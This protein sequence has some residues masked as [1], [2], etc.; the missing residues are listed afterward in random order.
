MADKSDVIRNVWK[1][2]INPE[3]EDRIKDLQELLS[4][5]SPKNL[6]K[7]PS[8]KH[9]NIHLI[10]SL[11]TWGK[12]R[13]LFEDLLFKHSFVALDTTFAIIPAHLQTHPAVDEIVGEIDPKEK[14]E[15][16]SSSLIKN[17]PEEI[18]RLH[19]IIIGF[20]SG[21]M[22][23]FETTFLSKTMLTPLYVLLTQD[24]TVKIMEDV[25]TQSGRIFEF[26]A[27][28]QPEVELEKNPSYV[29]V[30]DLI[31]PLKQWLPSRPMTDSNCDMS[32][33]SLAVSF[34]ADDFNPMKEEQYISLYNEKELIHVK[35]SEE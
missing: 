11:E 8:S 25:R 16:L 35:S 15:L 31:L 17:A 14:E 19:S 9:Q 12:E 22:F 32:L 7:D 13:K 30:I 6:Q 4:R 23:I 21:E 10:N 34:G 2:Y 29:Q 27:E 33:G 1:K 5:V 18:V 20:P 3:A 28:L 26:L 24:K